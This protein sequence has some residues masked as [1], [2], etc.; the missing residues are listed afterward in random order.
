MGSDSI[1]FPSKSILLFGDF[2]L[3]LVEFVAAATVGAMSVRRV[4]YVYVSQL[5]HGLTLACALI[6]VNGKNGLYSSSFTAT[7][8]NRRF[9]SCP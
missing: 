8:S 4:M 1:S 9:I 6:R 3:G 7:P 2:G 5:V